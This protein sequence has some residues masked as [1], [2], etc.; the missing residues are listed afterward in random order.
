MAFKREVALQ[1]IPLSQNNPSKRNLILNMKTSLE[2]LD[3]ICP[4]P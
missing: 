4:P 3:T 1:N 2:V